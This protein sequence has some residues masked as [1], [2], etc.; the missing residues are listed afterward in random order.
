MTRQRP[1]MLKNTKTVCRSLRMRRRD[2]APARAD[3]DM[4]STGR[5]RSQ[6]ERRKNNENEEK[7]GFLHETSFP[8]MNFTASGSMLRRLP[9]NPVTG[10]SA[11]PDMR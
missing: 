9:V 4:A 2:W 7:Q 10:R 11:A 5:T 3:R 8:K 1:L 6:E